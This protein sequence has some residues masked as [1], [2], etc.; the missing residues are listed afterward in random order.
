MNDLR[1]QLANTAIPTPKV[2]KHINLDNAI[3]DQQSAIRAMSDL[4]ARLNALPEE[5]TETGDNKSLPS[6]IEVLEN[7][8][9]RIRD[10]TDRIHKL[11]ADLEALLF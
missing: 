5:V 10:N 4:I 1:D 9:D 11:V 2:E 3:E 7:G 6:V 8:P